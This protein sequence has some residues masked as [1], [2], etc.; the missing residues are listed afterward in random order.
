MGVDLGAAGLR[1]VEVAPGQQV[2]ATDPGG[3]D[4]GVEV[5]VGQFVRWW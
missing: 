1:V 4:E 3:A 5:A 2:D